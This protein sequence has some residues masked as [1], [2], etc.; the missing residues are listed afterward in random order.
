M[1]NNCM[2]KLFEHTFLVFLQLLKMA[3]AKDTIEVFMV[4]DNACVSIYIYIHLNEC[5]I[6]SIA[7]KR[8]VF[9]LGLLKVGLQTAT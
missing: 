1:R 3:C 9:T 4:C 2:T 8:M 6:D 5:R 7:S